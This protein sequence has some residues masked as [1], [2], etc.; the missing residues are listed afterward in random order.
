MR[1]DEVQPRRRSALD[2]LDDFDLV[3]ATY[4]QSVYRTARAIVLDPSI[5]EDVTQEVFIK[6]FRHRDRY[7]SQGLL[8][9]WLLRI[10]TR[11]AISQLR[12]RR[13]QDRLLGSLLDAVRRP[14]AGHPA[15]DIVVELLARLSPGTRAAVVLNFYHG[16]RQREVADLLGIP[17]GTVATR[18]S[19]GI[20]QMRKHLDER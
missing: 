15:R 6:A 13:V 19:N 12:W 18:I 2:T 8:E 9:A 5:A 17:E 7:V 11:E 3:Y 10:A 16:Y 20:K 1:A 14:P 4:Y